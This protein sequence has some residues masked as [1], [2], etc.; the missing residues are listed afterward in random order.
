[1]SVQQPNLI[2]VLLRFIKKSQKFVPEAEWKI[3][4]PLNRKN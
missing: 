2:E 1:M 4:A 3:H